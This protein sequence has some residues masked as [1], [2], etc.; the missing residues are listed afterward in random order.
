MSKFYL[1]SYLYLLEREKIWSV[2]PDCRHA[3]FDTVY[4]LTRRLRMFEN[5]VLGW[6]FGSKRDE[7]TGEWRKLH[8]AEL[9]DLYSLPNIVQVVKLRGMRWAWHVAH[10]VEG[11]G[12][13]RVLVGKPEG[14]LGRPRH[15]WEV[16]I[17]LDHREVG[18][19]GDWMELVQ[20]R[21]RWRSL[22]NTVMN[23]RVP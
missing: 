8:N 11:R 4:V 10:L 12:E 6:V 13:H 23:F 20:Y 2:T 9:R 16:N 21:D 7:V 22:V 3:L 19:G 5:R 14:P 15:W 17:R 18:G 1:Y